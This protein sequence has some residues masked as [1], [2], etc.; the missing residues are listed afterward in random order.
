[1]L[2][3][4]EEKALTTQSMAQ[5][6]AGETIDVTEAKTFHVTESITV[7]TPANKTCL[8][9]VAEVQTLTFP[10]KAAATAGDYLVLEDTTGTKWAVAFD[11]TGS[12]TEPTGAIWVAIPAANKV[13]LDISATTDAPSVAAAVET[14][15]NLLTGF[16]DVITLNDGAADGTMTATQAVRGP[17]T[18]PVVKNADD[19][20]AGSISGVQTT[21]GVASAIAVTANTITIASHGYLSGLKVQVSINSGSLPTGLSA[22]TDY[23][24]IPVDTNTFKLATSLVNANA[25]TAIDLENQGDSAKT[26]TVAATSLAGATTK[27][28]RSLDGDVW[29]D[30]ASPAAQNITATGYLDFSVVDPSSRYIRLYHTLTAG[31]FTVVANVLTK[32]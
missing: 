31:Q 16:S 2:S 18:N 32:G 1:M 29:V 28:Q 7:T 19:S 10:A 6:T 5:S 15:M 25:G 11:K 9:G 26:I 17:A 24:V 8:T 20:G 30:V 21:A 3:R 4:L 12:D 13:F 27:L 14:A 23:F 22:S